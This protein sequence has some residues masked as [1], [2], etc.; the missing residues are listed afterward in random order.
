MPI[1][2]YVLRFFGEHDVLKSIWFYII[3][4]P[5]FAI[6]V[7]LSIHTEDWAYLGSFGAI[8]TMFSILDSCAHSAYPNYKN[9]IRPRCVKHGETWQLKHDNAPF[10]RIVDEKEALE[11]NK[12]QIVLANQKYSGIIRTYYLSLFGTAIWAYAG[13]WG[14]GH[15]CKIIS[16]FR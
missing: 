8:L 15:F 2:I 11:S 10:G 12:R 3:A 4:I 9:D 13:Y 16:V 14:S 7:Y 6:H 5:L 1:N